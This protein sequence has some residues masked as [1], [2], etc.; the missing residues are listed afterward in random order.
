MS[1]EGG[2]RHL[3]TI[4]SEETLLEGDP[5]AQTLKRRGAAMRTFGGDVVAM[6]Q[7]VQMSWAEKTLLAGAGGQARG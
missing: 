4:W 7:L 1:V 6:G 5:Q 2:W 3:R